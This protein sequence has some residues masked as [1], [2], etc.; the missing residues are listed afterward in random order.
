MRYHDF[1]EAKNLDVGGEQTAVALGEL[2]CVMLKMIFADGFVHADLHGGN[3]LVTP[4]AKWRCS[5]WDSSLKM[6]DTHRIAFARYFAA[7]ARGDSQT[8]AD[9]AVNRQ[10]IA[11]CP[12]PRRFHPGHPGFCPVDS[13]QTDS[14]KSSRQGRL[15]R[16]ANPASTAS[17]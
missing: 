1:I 2:G 9:I 14:A 13:R 6:D 8:M 10:S 11:L 7:W 5:T 17:A 16:T 4:E 12:R 15:R 3:L